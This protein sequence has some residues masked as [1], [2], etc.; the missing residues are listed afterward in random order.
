MRGVAAR[1]GCFVACAAVLAA[2]AWA[3]EIRSARATQ[4]EGYL[5]I[6]FDL[7]ARPDYKL[8]EIANPDRLV[9]DVGDSALAGGFAPPPG[10][11]VLKSVRTGR[12]AKRG[13]A[14]SAR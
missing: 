9:I 3:A 5:R 8:F 2:P 11:G 4:S 14:R 6:S 13:A 10:T 1:I 12:H 7:S